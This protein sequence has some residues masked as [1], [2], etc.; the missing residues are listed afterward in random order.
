MKKKLSALFLSAL[1]LLSLFTAC[2]SGKSAPAMSTE[3]SYDMA[4]PAMA[5]EEAVFEAEEAP[6]EIPMPRAAGGVGGTVDV[7]NGSTQQSKAAQMKAD[8]IIYTASAELE[9]AD[10]EATV[11]GVSALTAE[12]GG[13][14]ESSSVTGS[15]YYNYSRGKVGLRSASFT[16]R[17]PAESFQAFTS[18]LSELGN[19]PYLNTSSDNVTASYY[20]TESRMNAFKTQETRLIEMLSIAETVEDMLAIQQQLTEVQYEIDSLQSRLTNY[21]R[22]VSYS[23]V[24]LNVT[25]ME[26][27]TAPPAPVKKT[28]WEK[29][30]D[31]FADSLRSVG[32]FFT[33]LFLWFVTNLPAITVWAAAIF[34]VI[35][36]IRRAQRTRRENG[37]KSLRERRAERR[38]LKAAKKN[39]PVIPSVPEDKQE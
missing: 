9:T 3:A 15:N 32:K 17:I 1:M 14:M 38:A 29:M 25:E 23:T 19:V 7:S 27:Y 31:G 35:R 37:G 5:Y 20:D 28:Y 21:D 8:K 18:T 22:H 16:I 34:V 30:G 12:Y 26:E 6:A 36:L 39:E 24:Y 2:S 33:D 10:F 13:F 4:A 11:E